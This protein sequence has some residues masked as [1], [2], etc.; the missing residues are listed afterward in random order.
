MQG[1]MMTVLPDGTI[2]R[3]RDAFLHWTRQGSNVWSVFT[4]EVVATFTATTKRDW[5]DRWDQFIGSKIERGWECDLVGINPYW[6]G[7]VGKLPIQ[8]SN[9]CAENGSV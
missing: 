4:S 3:D 1:G 5:L 6:R 8:S 9:F 2:L 7:K